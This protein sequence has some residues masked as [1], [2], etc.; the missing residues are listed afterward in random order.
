[1]RED[2]N[3]NLYRC[4]RKSV[5]LTHFSLT[6]NEI[7]GYLQLGAPTHHLTRQWKVRPAPFVKVV[8]HTSGHRPHVSC[9][10]RSPAGKVDFNGQGGQVYTFRYH[11]TEEGVSFV[12]Q[13]QSNKL[14]HLLHSQP[15]YITG[16]RP[17]HVHTETKLATGNK[18][19]S[20]V[21]L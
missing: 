16:S 5:E 3:S 15:P 8:L 13:S 2:N 14:T 7:L 6:P 9:Y 19:P 1:M 11:A 12:D 21:S 4:P 10:T 18:S 20:A 17:T